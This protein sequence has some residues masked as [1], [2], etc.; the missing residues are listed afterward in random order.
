MSGS[1]GAHD[2]EKL[3]VPPADALWERAFLAVGVSDMR[4]IREP[5]RIAWDGAGQTAEPG[6]PTG[7]V[8]SSGVFVPVAVDGTK[9]AHAFSFDLALNGS[10][11]LFLAPLGR[12]TDVTLS[13]KWK[14]VSFQGDFLPEERKIDDSGFSARWKV[15]SLNRNYPQAWTGSGAAPRNEYCGDEELRP[16]EQSSFGLNLIQSVDAYRKTLRIAKYAFLFIVLTFAAFFL[17]EIL[18]GRPVH[19]VQYLLI[20]IPLVVFYILLLSLAEHIPFGWSYLV[21]A[22][23]TVSLISLYAR[24]VLPKKILAAVIGLVLAVLYGLLYA[25]LQCEDY[26]LLLGSFTLFGGLALVMRLTRDVNWYD[27]RPSEQEREDSAPPPPR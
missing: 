22:A 4:G 17:F 16:V 24:W 3:G 6:L 25:I 2:L 10:E 13:S 12:R 8:L 20:G 7:E 19:P 9:P 21:A 11:G 26:A 15:L 27:V 23:A 14:T 18:G 5:V 1:F